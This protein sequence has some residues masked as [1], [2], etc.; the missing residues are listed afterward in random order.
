MSP[1]KGNY[2]GLH[3]F[4]ENETSYCFSC[5]TLGIHLSF[6]WN[7]IN[8]MQMPLYC[9]AGLSHDLLSQLI[10][11]IS[12]GFWNRFHKELS[13]R[14]SNDAASDICMYSDMY[15]LLS[16]L[17]PTIYSNKIIQF[18]IYIQEKQLK[19]ITKEVLLALTSA[20]RILFSFSSASFSS[21]IL[22]YSCYQESQ[23]E[24]VINLL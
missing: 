21:T 16:D 2:T 13:H 7:C 3:S 19:K 15:V 18:L 17:D 5:H 20:S 24:F 8:V 14:V 6:L 4:P 11:L 1:L 22:S 10:C 23:E 9:L 12:N